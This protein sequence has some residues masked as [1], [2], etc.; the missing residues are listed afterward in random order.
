MASINL[1]IY[2]FWNSFYIYYNKIK[3][4]KKLFKKHLK[5]FKTI[6]TIKIKTR[7]GIQTKSANIL[8][9]FEATISLACLIQFENH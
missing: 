9:I 8:F 4:K 5:T 7:S 3:T 2:I 6:W 1:N